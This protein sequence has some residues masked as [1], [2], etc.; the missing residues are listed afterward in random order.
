MLMIIY[1]WG[2]KLCNAR[3]QYT[4]H[5]ETETEC[6]E[7]T[8]AH[9]TQRET[10]HTPQREDTVER[11]HIHIPNRESRENKHHTGICVCVLICVESSYR[12]WL[13]WLLT[14]QDYSTVFSLVCTS[15]KWAPGNVMGSEVGSFEMII[16]HWVPIGL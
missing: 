15:L 13:A 2:K 7:N 5:T 10:I 6:R 4:H 12:Y 14:T 1:Q 9:C 3:T 16:T 11:T 8:H